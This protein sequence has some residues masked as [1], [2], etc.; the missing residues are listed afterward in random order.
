MKI[1][2]GTKVKFLNNVGGGIV[3]GFTDEK[4]AMVEDTD[5]FVIPVLITDVVIDE[6]NL[7]DEQPKSASDKSAKARES[8]DSKAKSVISFEEMKFAP[9]KGEVLMAIKPETLELL[10]VSNFSLYLINESNYYFNFVIST[11]DRGAHTLVKTGL[12][13]PNSKSNVKSF[14]QTDIAKIQEIR[15]QG[16]FYKHGLFEISNAIDLNFNIGNVSFYKVGYFSDNKYFD[17][18]ALVLK[19]EEIDL[20]EAFQKLTESDIAIVTREKEKAEKKP[21]MQSPKKENSTVEVDLHIEALIDDHRNMSNGEILEIQ[22]K[23]FET[24]FHEAILLKKQ[25][26]VF[27]HGVGNGKLKQEIINKLKR[28]YPDFQY[29]DASFK[30]Y[31]FG[32]TMVYLR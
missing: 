18:K 17:S 5:G 2:I 27:I 11:F 25:K 19:K 8:E 26:I 14:T 15:L 4:I 1:K 10:H 29:Q 24:S 23:Q 32:A 22:L 16:I 31:G 12:I 13:K 21:I 3:R 9:F 7:Y 20:K 6:G 30:E 28:N